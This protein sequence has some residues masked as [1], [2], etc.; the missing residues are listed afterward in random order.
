MTEKQKSS[1]GVNRT[2]RAI[3]A[4]MLVLIITFCAIIICQDTGKSLRA[5]ITDQKLYTLCD[6]TKSILGKL[7]QPIKLKLYYAKTAA[8]KAPDQIRYFN[9][10]YQFVKSLVEEYVWASEGMV[11]LEVIDPRPFSEEE[12]DA[13]RYGIKRFPITE[14]ESFFFGLVVQTRFG[15]EK[16]IPFFSPDRQNFVEYDI[17]YL[18]DTA[19]TRKK[20]KIG[21]MSSLEVMGDDITPYMEQMMRMQGQRPKPAWTVITHLQQQYEVKSIPTDA[22]EI[23]DIDIL[24][25]IHP[26]NLKERT[27]FAIDQ[28]ILKGGRAVI[29]IDPYCFV[30]YPSP[31]A[32]QMQ[33]PE[34]RHSQ[35]DKL[36]RS[37]GLEMKKNTFAADMNLA[38]KASLDN[39]SRPETIAPFLDLLAPNCFNTDSVLTATLNEVR[40]LFAGSLQPIASDSNETAINRTALIT[41]TDAGGTISIDNPHEV[42]YLNASQLADR[43]VSSRGPVTMGYLITG[44]L[45]SSFPEGIQIPVESQDANAT[46]TTQLLTGITEAKQDCAVVVFSDVDF[47]A[48]MLAYQD[49]FFGKIVIA[50]NSTLLMNSIDDLLG[51]DDLIS[52][53]SRGNFK[54]PFTVVDSIEKQ[55]QAD[56]AEQEEKINAEIKAFQSELN[57]LLGTAKQG[58]EKIIGSTILSK[59]KALE[60]NIHQAKRQLR[61]VKMQKRQSLENLGNKLRNFNMLTAPAVILTIAIVLSIRR[62][63]RK[64]HYISHASDS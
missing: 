2:V 50:D 58:E 33:I 15:V 61:E 27:L 10:Y 29:C 57:K 17:S 41:T 63:V 3:I 56:T 45:T 64:R 38:L 60:L 49:T 18:I 62:S 14:E 47:V 39:K 42:K 25:V 44:K 28:F 22:N 12:A 1:S 31:R 54:R 16:S 9:N 46:E 30:D 23:E 8:I 51:S 32:M 24:L 55:A 52:I 20:N 36:L 4:V 7:N 40:V 26:K 21:V 34:T 48:D 43:F 37:W 11:E 53:R 13:I 5:D 19:T 6:G 59:K 35:V